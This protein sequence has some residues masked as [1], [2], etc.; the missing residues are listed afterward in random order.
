M[1]VVV[2]V[3]VVEG[4]GLPGS[5]S[6]RKGTVA[7]VWS[8]G[9]S[10][11]ECSGDCRGSGM[12][13]TSGSFGVDLASSSFKKLRRSSWKKKEKMKRQNYSNQL[14]LLWR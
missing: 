6:H 2:V 9:V 8:G 3:V 5:S 13:K 10:I 14:V 7:E 4:R 1:A 11:P 12:V